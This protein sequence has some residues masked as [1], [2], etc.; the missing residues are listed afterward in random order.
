MRSEKEEI[1][2]PWVAKTKAFQKVK[3]WFTDR[4]QIVFGVCMRESVY[5]DDAES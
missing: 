4:E 1:F 2:S 3:F 5:D